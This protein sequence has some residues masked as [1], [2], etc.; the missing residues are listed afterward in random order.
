MLHHRTVSLGTIQSRNLHS[1][2]C[3]HSACM[4]SPLG[5]KSNSTQ[6]LCCRIKMILIFD[7]KSPGVLF[8]THLKRVSKL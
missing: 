3:T 1:Y 6:Q 8:T 4:L 7:K 5:K 2:R